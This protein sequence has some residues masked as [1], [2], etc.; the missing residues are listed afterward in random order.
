[1]KKNY[2]GIAML[3]ILILSFASCKKES[4]EFPFQDPGLSF[5]ERAADLV[6]HLTL[7][8]KVAQMLNNAP[9]IERFNIPPY[10]WW[11]E[12]LHGVGRTDYNV[13]VYP[14]AIAMAA[15]WDKEAIKI[16]AEQTAEEGRA[17]YNTSSAKGDY[18]R[19]YGLTYWTP[20]INIFRD[21]RWGRGQ[22]TYGEDPYLTAMLGKNFVK[23]LQGHDDRYWK[24]A[25]CAKHFAVHSG[26]EHN[27]HEFNVEVSNYDL[28]DTYLP[29]F[30]ELVDVDVAGIMCAYNAYEGQPCCSSDK[31]MIEILRNDWN[32]TGYVTSD[33]GAIDDFFNFHKTHP[34]KASAAADAVFHG[35][36]LECGN[37]TYYTLVDAVRNGQLSEEVINTSLKRLFIIRMK[38]GLLDPKEK[39]P[40]NVIDSTRLEA[41]QP[42]RNIP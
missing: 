24:A 25:G 13:T 11:N 36:D 2:F 4:Y 37:S 22:E 23:G 20:N 16:M 9:A 26:P 38:L 1:M 28:W 12:C 33:C 19:Y 40:Y 34:D 7:E 10:E 21:P 32:F 17:I 18:S 15:G 27:R 8:E 41:P 6:S 29:A 5:E 35:T 31:L 3:T 30:K 14:Q 42:I 39:V